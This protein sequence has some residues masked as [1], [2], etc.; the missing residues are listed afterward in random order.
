MWRHRD[1]RI[2]SIISF[3][4][5]SAQACKLLSG[6]CFAFRINIIFFPFIIR[7]SSK[8]GI[9]LSILK[10]TQKVRRRQ[11]IA[12][13]LLKFHSSTK[14]GSSTSH[15]SCRCI[16]LWQPHLSRQKNVSTRRKLLWPDFYASLHSHR[17]WYFLHPTA[18]SFI[19]TTEW[20]N[21]KNETVHV[22]HFS[23]RHRKKWICKS[24]GL[25]KDTFV[26]INDS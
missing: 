26:T 22:T 1:T 15:F 7:I 9:K 18:R 4:N 8:A 2:I 24:Q 6:E 10:L 19:H 21:F 5:V 16:K 17:F 3:K 13:E 20:C 12:D 25:T 11:K 14:K 23:K